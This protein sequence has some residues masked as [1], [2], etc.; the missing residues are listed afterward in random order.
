MGLRHIGTMVPFSPYPGPVKVAA[1]CGIAFLEGR[2][3]LFSWA[4]ELTGIS[5]RFA[6]E[7][8]N[9]FK[10]PFPTKARFTEYDAGPGHGPLREIVQP[11]E[12]RGAG[13]QISIAA[14]RVGV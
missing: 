8:G 1:R 2:A 14:A 12:G 6:L 13:G 11:P 9:N 4:S 5:T 3:E 7:F 10:D